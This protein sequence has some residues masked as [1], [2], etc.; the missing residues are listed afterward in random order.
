[1]AKVFE[2]GKTYEPADM[3][4]DRIIVTRRTEKTVWVDNGISQWMMR[5][6]KDENGNEWCRDSKAGRWADA[7]VYKAEWEGKE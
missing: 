2:V 3:G 4:F 1:M 7:F 6:R 5:V